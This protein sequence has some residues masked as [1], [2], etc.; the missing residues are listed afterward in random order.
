MREANQ[1]AYHGWVHRYEKSNKKRERHNPCNRMFPLLPAFSTVQR[2]PSCQLPGES[3]RI[4]TREIAQEE[5]LG[6]PFP[7]ISFQ[8]KD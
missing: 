8:K 7:L 1:R 6:A 3:Y 4:F 5:T 2:I